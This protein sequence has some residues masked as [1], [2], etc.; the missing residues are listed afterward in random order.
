MAYIKLVATG[1]IRI[2]IDGEIFWG[3]GT[4][5]LLEN[6]KTYDSLREPAIS[7]GLSYQKFIMLSAQ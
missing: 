6:I 5:E 3:A 2:E 7:T 4:V 1:R